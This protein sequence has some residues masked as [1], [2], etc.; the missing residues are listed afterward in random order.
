MK[1]IFLIC[2]IQIAFAQDERY[3]RELFSGELTQEKKVDK[4]TYK[5]TANSPFYEM[6]LG[7]TQFPESLVIEK[8]DGEDWLYIHDEKKV[9]IFSFKF[10]V[11]GKDSLIYRVSKRR[12]SKNTELL[13]FYYYEG[14]TDFRNF[15]GSVRLYFLTIDNRDLSTISMFKG[16]IYWDEREMPGGKYSQKKFGIELIDFNHD[17]KMEIAVGGKVLSKVYFYKSGGK[18]VGI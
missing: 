18:W 4:K 2:F 3:F 13:I 17:G 15:K 9:R 16:P 11:N 7:G 12:L 6:D 1:I 5:W 14:N 8:K 10:D